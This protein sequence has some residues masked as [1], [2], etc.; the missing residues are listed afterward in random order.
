[1]LSLSIDSI[2]FDSIR[3]LTNSIFNLLALNRQSLNSQ[4]LFTE[5]KKTSKK[6]LKEI[7]VRGLVPIREGVKHPKR[8]RYF[9]GASYLNYLMLIICLIIYKIYCLKNLSERIEGEDAC[10]C[11]FY[12]FERMKP[13]PTYPK[14]WDQN[15]VVL[16]KKIFF[17]VELILKF[18]ENDFKKRQ[19][20][21]RHENEKC[22]VVWF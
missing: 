9:E 2:Q 12:W 16:S 18:L 5:R 1:M 19:E 15:Q 21:S 17:C 7:K 22:E 4:F 11:C 14:R 3:Y 13:L 8:L 10:F 20:A 6:T